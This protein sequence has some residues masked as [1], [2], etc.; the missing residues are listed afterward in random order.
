MFW[1]VTAVNRWAGNDFGNNPPGEKNRST[2]FSRNNAGRRVSSHTA[3]FKG[4]SSEACLI[5]VTFGGKS[6]R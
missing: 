2:A 1:N 4:F 6:A 5:S 3:R